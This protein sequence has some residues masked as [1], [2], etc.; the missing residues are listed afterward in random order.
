MAQGRRLRLLLQLVLWTAFTWED[1]E[2]GPRVKIKRV[3]RNNQTEEQAVSSREQG[4]DAATHSEKSSGKTRAE[5]RQLFVSKYLLTEKAADAL[6]GYRSGIFTEVVVLLALF[7]IVPLL[8]VF[9]AWVYQDIEPSGKVE[10]LFGPIC[11]GF[12]QLA[13]RRSVTF[14]SDGPPRG[15]AAKSHATNRKDQHDHAK[16]SSRLQG[17]RSSSG[18]LFSAWSE[19]GDPEDEAQHHIVCPDADGE[20][21]C[22]ALVNFDR[23]ALVAIVED[24]LDNED[25]Q[26][27][28]TQR[29]LPIPPL[30]NAASL[31]GARGERASAWMIEAVTRAALDDDHEELFARMDKYLGQNVAD[32]LGETEIGWSSPLASARTTNFFGRRS[33]GNHP[34]GVLSTVEESDEQEVEGRLRR[35]TVGTIAPPSGEAALISVP[36]ALRSSRSAVVPGVTEE[37]TSGRLGFVAAA[38]PSSKKKTDSKKAPEGEGEGA[39][40]FE[41]GET[42]GDQS[43]SK[44]VKRNATRTEQQKKVSLRNKRH[45]SST[46]P[47]SAASMM[48][49]RRAG[50]ARSRSSSPKE[51]VQDTRSKTSVRSARSV[52]DS[53]DGSLAATSGTPAA[54]AQS[55]KG[56]R[57]GVLNRKATF[58]EGGGRLRGIEKFRRAAR[59]LIAI[60]HGQFAKTSW[61]DVALYGRGALGESILHICLFLN[62]P[63]HRLIAKYLVT[64]LGERV[65]WQRTYLPTVVRA[66]DMESYLRAATGGVDGGAQTLPAFSSNRSNNYASADAVTRNAFR[67]RYLQDTSQSGTAVGVNSSATSTLKSLGATE[68]KQL[69]TLGE[70]IDQL[71]G[72]VAAKRVVSYISASYTA[73]SY[74]GE[75]AIHIAIMNNDLQMLRVLLR[76]GAELNEAEKSGSFFQGPLY[77]GALPLS[78]AVAHSTPEIAC[79]LIDSGADPLRADVYGNGWLHVAVLHA[80]GDQVQAVHAHAPE[81]FHRAMRSRNGASLTPLALA[82][83]TNQPALFSLLLALHSEVVWSYGPMTC[84]RVPLLV[85]DSLLA[86]QLPND[87]HILADMDGRRAE[88]GEDLLGGAGAGEQEGVGVEG[89]NDG[90]A[91]R[92]PQPSSAGTNS[93]QLSRLKSGH[94][95]VV[96]KYKKKPTLS[97][98]ELLAA[99]KLGALCGTPVME[100]LTAN[101]WDWYGRLIHMSYLL[102]NASLL[103]LL[104]LGGTEEY[105]DAEI[106]VFGLLGYYLLEGLVFAVRRGVSSLFR[107][108]NMG[109]L[110]PLLWVACTVAAY[111]CELSDRH[112]DALAFDSWRNRTVAQWVEAQAALKSAQKQPPTAASRAAA[113]LAAEVGSSSSFIESSEVAEREDQADTGDARRDTNKD[114]RRTVSGFVE[115]AAE[116]IDGETLLE[117]D[118]ESESE[119]PPLSVS[120]SSGQRDREEGK[121]AQIFSA[122]TPAADHGSSTAEVSHFAAEKIAATNHQD[123]VPRMR[124]ITDS[125][126]DEQEHR[127]RAASI[128]ANAMPRDLLL[129]KNLTTF[130]DHPRLLRPLYNYVQRES[131]MRAVGEVPWSKLLFGYSLII[132]SMCV[133]SYLRPFHPIGVYIVMFKKMIVRDFLFFL[134]IFLMVMGGFWT[135]FHTVLRGPEDAAYREQQLFENWVATQTQIHNWTSTARGGEHGGAFNH[136]AAASYDA[137]NRGAA[138]RDDQP[139]ASLLVDADEKNST[140]AQRRPGFGFG[141]DIWHFLFASSLG[142]VSD[143]PNEPS[144]RRTGHPVLITITYDAYIMLAA[145]VAVP[146]LIAM[147]TDTFEVIRTEARQEWLLERLET[148]LRAERT[149]LSTIV[150]LMKLRPHHQVRLE[151]LKL[152]DGTE[153]QNWAMYVQERSDV[154]GGG[155]VG[156]GAGGA[157]VGPAGY[158]L[159]AAPPAT[160][161]G[162]EGA[163]MSH[164]VDGAHM[165]GVGI[166]G[167]GETKVVL[168]V[169]K[170]AGHQDQ[171]DDDAPLLE[172]EHTRF[173]PTAWEETWP[174][175]PAGDES[176]E[177]EEGW[178]EELQSEMQNPALRKSLKAVQAE[179]RKIRVGVAEEAET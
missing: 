33:H 38:A 126:A 41:S 64:R 166:A 123:S 111:G 108:V 71:A 61:R 82:A 104:V 158:A 128:V 7:L 152:S 147:M 39:S 164:R 3:S 27:A 84:K 31:F 91:A 179:F 42:S 114:K 20:P 156:G 60:Q 86:R 36:P 74:R 122:K 139:S 19:S 59:R 49:R 98:M 113:S 87:E 57:V 160:G 56:Y 159:A 40:G 62:T 177:D 148:I 101:K 143:L 178:A 99:L 45:R 81:D 103:I 23:G 13:N 22:Y 150:P 11:P 18:T 106:P 30:D 37:A 137:K 29:G 2:Q 107:G 6:D 175:D 173:F 34:V 89:A 119:L 121:S 109:W 142:E 85:L 65:C 155:L 14:E 66:T 151:N 47:G 141:V 52:E 76:H 24:Y 149:A 32:R 72:E 120:V 55:G 146:L 68:Q 90:G 118:V 125:H 124:N 35:S 92:E 93:K 1:G 129:H 168:A 176:D 80:R 5:W 43:G 46:P 78:C 79:E 115:E 172:E 153:I 15:A 140:I 105:L 70:H 162:P 133:L 12:A 116:E 77:S 10:D 16:R 134:I 102:L 136:T 97:V 50:A 44:K 157:P 163:A 165:V 73:R 161:A 130:E 100:E 51:T 95:L 167:A 174:R 110:L 112:E 4:Q 170:P 131:G 17:R 144:V 63:A 26:S 94:G 48:G 53:A 21:L 58:D 132:G 67:S 96:L 117:P 54:A 28:P 69:Q 154:F 25:S 83:C 8:V 88:G 145:L 135:F 127:E 9:V 75:S 138:A 169:E 171:A